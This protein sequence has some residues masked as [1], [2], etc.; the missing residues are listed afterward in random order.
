MVLGMTGAIVAASPA[1][2]ST[3]LKG[4]MLAQGEYDRFTAYYGKPIPVQWVNCDLPHRRPVELPKGRL[5][6]A[7]G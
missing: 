3:S 7:I 1:S 4:W 6:S 5:M 2:A